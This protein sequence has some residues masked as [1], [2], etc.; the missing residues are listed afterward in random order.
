MN[1]FTTSDP[2]RE[3]TVREVAQ[4]SG[5]GTTSPVVVGT[6]AQVAD[7]LQRWHEDAGVD[8]FNV[9]EV[10]RTG[11]LDDAVDLLVPE[12]RARGLLAERD[13]GR[14]SANGC[15]A[16]AAPVGVPSRAAVR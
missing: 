1:A 13:P 14:R 10:L 6:P 2:D 12:L 11:S 8:G 3:W 16:G 7:E 9:K 4:F 5:L 15:S